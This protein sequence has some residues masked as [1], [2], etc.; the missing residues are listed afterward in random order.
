MNKLRFLQM[1]RGGAAISVM[2]SH[3]LFMF[4]L[5]NET[6]AQVFPYLP[7]IFTNSSKFVV[8]FNIN[9]I[10]V[11][12]GKFRSVWGSNILSDQWFCYTIII[13]T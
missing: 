5:Q 3:L 13:G 8:L 9:E 12:G 10:L 4:F 2:I 11:R 6:M 1:L 7:Q